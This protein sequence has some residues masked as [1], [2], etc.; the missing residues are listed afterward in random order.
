MKCI[1]TLLLIATLIICYV[2]Y[3]KPVA[4]LGSEEKAVTVE[5][6]KASQ[7]SLNNKIQLLGTTFS[8]NSIDI[9]SEVAGKIDHIYVS[10]GEYIQAGTLLF[11]LDNRHQKAVLK[12][13]QS[14]LAEQKRQ[15]HNLLQLLPKGAVKQSDVDLAQ[16]EIEIQR[17]ELKIAQVA[18][19]NSYIRAPFSGKLGL[20]DISP[21]QLVDTS[22]LL[23]S[24]DD[25]S[26]LRINIPISAQ[27]L[28]QLKVGEIAMV[29][30]SEFST[31]IPTT[32]TTLDSRI[33][34]NTLN[35]QAQFT[36]D[37]HKLNLTPGSMVSGELS[38]Y[39]DPATTIPL[40]SVV[41]KGSKRYV[42]KLNNDQRVEKI[43]VELGL[44]NGDWVQVNNGLQVDDIVVYKGTVKL[45]DHML[46]EVIN[47]STVVEI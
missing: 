4:T 46:V 13:E 35:I 18:L 42:F 29:T 31:P 5:V 9:R 38:L 6:V 24:L 20:I 37:N 28:R 43:A 44:R 17:A 8:L 3:Q 34:S 21:G 2:L 41:Y 33:N 10:S 30:S 25:A 47:T 40:Q 11:S 26:K 15:Y 14:R 39:K 23:T 7:Q 22:T 32:L 1:T 19:D 36:I 45:R 27:Y 12:R 16:A